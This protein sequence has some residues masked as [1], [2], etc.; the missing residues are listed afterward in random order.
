MI[1]SKKGINAIANK[2]ERLGEGDNWARGAISLTEYL[3][4]IGAETFVNKAFAWYNASFARNH[5]VAG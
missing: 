1:V 4:S 5:P 2:A 3:R